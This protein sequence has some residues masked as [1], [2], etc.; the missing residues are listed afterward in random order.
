MA[1]I[2]LP[3]DIPGMRSLLAFRPETAAP[4]PALAQILLH[5]YGQRAALV[6]QHGYVDV[7]TPSPDSTSARS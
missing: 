4:I 6:A 2:Q 7:A 5:F 1:H 3:A